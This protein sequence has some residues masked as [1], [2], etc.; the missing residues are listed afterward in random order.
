MGSIP[1]S[2]SSSST[3]QLTVTA[4]ELASTSKVQVVSGKIGTGMLSGAAPITV[5]DVPASAFKDGAVDLPVANGN[6][7]HR[8]QIVDSSGTVAH[9][10]GP[11]WAG[12][13]NPENVPEE[14]FA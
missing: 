9:F 1:R 12:V 14:R 5:T 11:V 10:T 13:P 4:T 2:P 8:V 3:A 7:Y 6:Y